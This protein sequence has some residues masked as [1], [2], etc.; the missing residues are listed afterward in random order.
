MVSPFRAVVSRPRRREG[1]CGLALSLVSSRGVALPDTPCFP[2][3]RQSFREIRSL[4]IAVLSPAFTGPQANS[5]RCEFRPPSHAR[6][7]CGLLKISLLL[8]I[9]FPEVRNLPSFQRSVE[10]DE[11][12]EFQEYVARSYELRNKIAARV[13]VRQPTHFGFVGRPT[14]SAG[15]IIWR[16][17]GSR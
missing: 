15:Q 11:R 4:S 16:S 7:P 12:L 13:G 1:F 5:I 10:R 8:S 3:S 6:I 9:I 17:S 2:S 14:R